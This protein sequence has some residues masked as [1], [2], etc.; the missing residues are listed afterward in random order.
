MTKKTKQIT[1][2]ISEDSFKK[3]EK[4]CE[5]ED[6]SINNLVTRI[7]TKYLKQNDSRNI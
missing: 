1:A 5:E 6:R 2:R 4:L 7:I 3:L